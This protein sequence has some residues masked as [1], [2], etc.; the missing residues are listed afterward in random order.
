VSLV[1][2]SFITFKTNAATL[3]LTDNLVLRDIDDKAVEHGFLSKKQ[4]IKLSKGNHT[5]V[6]KY[7]DVFEDIDFAEERLVKSDYFVVKF[8]V[9][10]QDTLTLSTIIIRDLDAAERFSKKPEL[11]L[12]D[13]DKQE[14]ALALETLD[15][16][17]LAK[18]VTQVVT[19]L[20]ATDIA[21]Q[22]INKTAISSDVEQNFNNKVIDKVDA[23]PMLKYWWKKADQNEKDNFIRFI[24]ETK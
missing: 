19:T 17:K 2:S 13:E 23:V 9:S 15:N 16:Y 12:L 24:N 20:S 21:A 8:V 14:V 4:S 7:K 5:L 3:T 18:Q 22:G 6:V 11:I 10:N 1:V